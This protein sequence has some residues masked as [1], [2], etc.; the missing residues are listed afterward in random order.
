M[1]KSLLVLAAMLLV[2][3]GNDSPTAPTTATPTP[4]PT[5]TPIPTPT[6]TPT[7]A[8]PELPILLA[9]E[10][11]AVI[12]QNDLNSG[13]PF[14]VER[15]AGYRIDFDWAD[16]AAPAG[17]VGYE[18]Q[19]QRQQTPDPLVYASVKTSE[20][21]L[22][23]C[24]GYVADQNL[25]GWVW[26]VRGVDRLGRLGPWAERPFSFAPCRIGQRYCGS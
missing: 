18:I 3:C 1:R 9:P 11:N 7:P 16:L 15:G 23:R 6:P 20:Y 13:C 10:A 26:S 14:D 2:A 17:L 4:T 21:H 25:E 5:P 24:G 22:Q 8:P 12:P 19:V